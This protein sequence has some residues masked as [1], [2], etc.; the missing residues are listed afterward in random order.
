MCMC[1]CVYMSVNVNVNQP[2]R[3]T[4]DCLMRTRA[5]TVSSE[6]DRCD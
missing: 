4:A 5:S 2:S 1:V 3:I 6:F